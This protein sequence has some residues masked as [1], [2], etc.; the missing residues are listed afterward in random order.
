M[1]DVARAFQSHHLDH[2]QSFAGM[3]GKAATGAANQSLIAKFGPR[4]AGRRTEADLLTATLEVETAAAA[5]YTA[6]LAQLIGTNP[7]AL[8]ASIQPIEARH[9][10]VLGEALQ[11]PVD[12]YTPVF[13]TTAAAADDRP[14][15]D[16]GEV[17]AWIP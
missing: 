4:P 2:A 3:A 8:V 6:G 17:S 10:A 7:A 16:R 13:E 14:V 11:L 9:A 1:A 15:P 12:D 5:T